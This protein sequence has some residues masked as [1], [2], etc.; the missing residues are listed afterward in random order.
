MK[1]PQSAWLNSRARAFV[2]LLRERNM[3]MTVEAA[4]VLIAGRVHDVGTAMGIGVTSAQRY[5]DDAAIAALAEAV[6]A[7]LD[8]EDPGT[9]LLAAPRTATVPVAL[10]GRFIAGIAEASIV[11]VDHPGIDD[12]LRDLRTGELTRLI[13]VCGLIQSDHV[14]GDVSVPAVGGCTGAEWL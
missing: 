7:Q 14:D 11:F 5:L 6:V 13:S 3:S 10:L 12:N 9:D 1:E 4:E 8:D 2:E